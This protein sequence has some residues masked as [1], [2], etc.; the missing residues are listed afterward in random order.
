MLF[1]VQNDPNQLNDLA[2]TGD[3]NEQRMKA[4]LVEAL[5]FMEAPASQ[6]TRLHLDPK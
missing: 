1:D 4:L 5:Q 6:F 3:S 2:G